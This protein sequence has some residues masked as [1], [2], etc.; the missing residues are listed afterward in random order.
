MFDGRPVHPGAM[1]SW[2]STPRRKTD[3]ASFAHANPADFRRWLLVLR[4]RLARV[5]A[6][7]SMVC[8]NA[9][10]GWVETA[11]LEPD[12]R[13]GMANLE[14]VRSVFGKTPTS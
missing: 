4:R 5:A 11:Y 1:P 14:A 12:N 2:D 10:N 7:D 13:T 9:W 6:P 8:L 3:A